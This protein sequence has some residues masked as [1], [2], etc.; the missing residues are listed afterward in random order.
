MTLTGFS[1][2][3]PEQVLSGEAPDVGGGTGGIFSGDNRLLGY[4]L[5]GAGV[6][7]AVID[8][9]RRDRQM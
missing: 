7:L 9:I 8:I 4:S 3:I 5:F 6:I 2:S 1:P